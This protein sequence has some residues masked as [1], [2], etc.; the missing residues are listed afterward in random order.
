MAALS[1]RADHAQLSVLVTLGADGAVVADESGETRIAAAAVDVVDTT[2]A[3]DCLSGVLASALLEGLSLRDAATRAVR[4]A[5]LSTA[6]R[7]A[8]EGMPTREQLDRLDP[9]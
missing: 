3:G 2:G 7:G 8:R 5:S 6:V 1:L 9:S 4:A